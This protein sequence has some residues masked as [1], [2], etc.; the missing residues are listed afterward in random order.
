MSRSSESFGRWTLTARWWCSA[1]LEWVSISREVRAL[2]NSF[3]YKSDDLERVVSDAS[4]ISPKTG[5]AH[6][7]KILPE[8]EGVAVK[9]YRPLI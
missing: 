8:I 2:R 6:G 3:F 1:N 4:L 9:P 5:F 7:A